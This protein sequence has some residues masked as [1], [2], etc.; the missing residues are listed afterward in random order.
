MLSASLNKNTSFLAASRDHANLEDLNKKVMDAL[1]M[2]HSLMKENPGYGYSMKTTQQYPPPGMMPGQV[3]PVSSLEVCLVV[4]HVHHKTWH[5]DTTKTMLFQTHYHEYFRGGGGV[6][7]GVGY[8]W[9]V[10]ACS[11]QVWSVKGHALALSFSLSNSLSLSP[12]FVS[13][14]LSFFV[15]LSSSLSYFSSVYL[16][17]SL[18]LSVSL[19][20][21]L[22]LSLSL[23]LTSWWITTPSP[24]WNIAFNQM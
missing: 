24:S 12:P 10:T 15:S 23:S 8:L 13:L 9:Y 17:L 1:Q 21:S 20:V 6:G 18:S 4:R 7:V 2:Y 3:N 16:S 14:A 22:S 5:V 11:E 19:S